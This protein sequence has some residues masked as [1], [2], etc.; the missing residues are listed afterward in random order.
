MGRIEG[1]NP[2]LGAVIVFAMLMGGVSVTAAALLYPAFQAIV[3]RWWSSGLCFGD[4]EVRS[5][6]RM[7][8]VYAA[9]ARFVGYALLFS[10]A[11]GIVAAIALVV[12]GAATSVAQ[13]G[14]GGEILANSFDTGWLRRRGARFFDDLSRHRAAV[15]L[16]IG[17]G[18]AAA[19]RSFGARKGQSHRTAKLRDRRRARRRAE[20]G[21]LLMSDLN[22]RAA[23]MNSGPGVYFDGVTSVRRDV[24][25]TLAPSS[26]RISA[27]DGRLLAEW[28]YDD[29]EELAAPDDVLRLGLHGST[30]LARLEI[31]DAAFAAEIDARAS[32][33]D[34][35]GTL[36]R[37][38]RVRVIGWTVAATA[39]L[40]LVAWFGVP[41]IAAR[42]TPLLP[43]SGRAQAG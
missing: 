18:I 43:A 30:T 24:A 34:R 27:E 22:R 37:R 23:S 25:V 16:A 13:P 17:H 36:Q 9:Y 1:G 7:R 2:G 6:L 41:A 26:L 5:R 28:P 10:M 3:L 19:D 39:S 33:V 31:F 11:V 20:C 4:L 21:R 29:I 42:L 12:I 32:L 14:A 40:V 38:Q 8:H 35:T 15:A